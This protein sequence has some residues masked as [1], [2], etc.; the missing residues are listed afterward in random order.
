MTTP[1]RV[2]IV[3]D[4]PDDAELM[5]LHL[6][7]EGFQPD[8]RRV[9]TEPDYRAALEAP[10][11]LI[12]ADW[13][14]PQ[15]SGL[16]AL[17]LMREHGLDVPFVIVSGSIGE[18]A[19]V[20]CMKQGAAD[21]LLKDRLARLGQAVERALAEKSLRDERARLEEQVR[22]QERLA[23]IGQLAGGIAHDFNNLLTTI[24]LYAQMPLGKHDLHP[25]VRR[26]LETILGESR[27]AARLVRQILDFSRRSPIEARPVDLQPFV[28]E[29]V[30]VLQR[31]I[32]EHVSFHLDVGP[33]KYVV[34]ADPTRVQQVLM[35]LVLNA[36]D[37]M[38]KGGE[39]R[40]GLGQIVTRPD[41]PLPLPEMKDVCA[42]G[43]R[44]WVCLTVSDTGAGM[45]EEVK[46]H[47]FEPFFTTKAHGQGTGLGLAQVHGIV[48]QHKG[49]IQVES[50]GGRGTTF[51]V[52]LPAHPASGAVEAPEK[53][54]IAPE[55]KGETVLLVEDNEKLRR[56]AQEILKSLGYRVLP[57]ANGR[58]ALETC[59][60][61]M[62]KGQGI[63]LILTDMVMPEMGGKELI[64]ELKKLIP[65]VKVLA[66]TGHTMTEDIEE[67]KA[68]DIQ[69][70][71]QK[72]FEIDT[73]AAAIRRALEPV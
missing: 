63:D 5:A 66:T 10:P 33:G 44:E 45:T 25:D 57:A 65:D 62:E 35:N 24:M 68:A 69:G 22:R 40:I 42:M 21:Y 18:E 34:D 71:I 59:R 12:L 13:S 46:A 51:R 72:P 52:Y 3:E 28:E 26:A 58:E 1:L 47:L 15:F 9:Q 54:G 36:R 8:W 41:Q 67:L 27:Q 31:T 2:L 48:K 38:P 6:A 60:S 29:S 53:T 39:L 43:C 73:L 30:R 32:P 49:Y 14:L 70:T 23:A 11:D 64:Q 7:E 37:A 16:R 55:G 19:A 17:Q 50:E 56:V 20:E 61:A 4:S